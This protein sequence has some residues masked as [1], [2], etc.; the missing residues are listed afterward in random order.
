MTDE[1]SGIESALRLLQSKV[2]Y[3]RHSDIYGFR[4]PTPL[5]S[6]GDVLYILKT[7]S[8]WA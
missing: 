6:N 2:E 1:I 3:V 4:I 7:H 8:S 5:S